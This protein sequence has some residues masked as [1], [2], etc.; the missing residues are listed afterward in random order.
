MSL[1]IE[2]EKICINQCI[3]NKKENIE[4]EGDVI[5]PDIKPDILKCINTCGTI[6]IYKKEV[7]DGKVRI[8]GTINVNIIY[9]TDTENATIRGITSTIDFSKTIEM[10]SAKQNMNIEC[11]TK[12]NGIECRI[13]NGRKVNLKAIVEVSIGLN[14][15]DEIEFIKSCDSID[16]IQ[17]LNQNLNI[18]TLVGMGNTNA[19]AKDTLLID[20]IDNL[21][22]IL[23]TNVD[24]I[25]IETKK[26]YNK[27]LIKADLYAKIMYLTDDGRINS[28]ESKIPIMGF[29]DMPDITED[30]ACETRY[31]LKNILVKPNNIEEHSIYVEAE[32][33]FNCLAFQNKEVKL[34][35]DS[36]SPCQNIKCD[37]KKINTIGKKQEIKDIC[38]VREKHVIPEIRN[39]KIYDVD[40]DCYIKKQ[41]V[42][43]NRITTE[44]EIVVNFIYSNSINNGIDVKRII[45]PFN[46]NTECE[47]LDSDAII[48]TNL[49]VANQDAIVMPDD[50]IELKIDLNIKHL[51]SENVTINVIKNISIEEDIEEEIYGITIYF[52]KPGDTLWNIAKKF[53][54]TTEAII[55]LNN[56]EDESRI[57]VGQ[58]IF[59]PKYVKDKA[60][61]S[62]ECKIKQMAGV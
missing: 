15:N 29:I 44:G 5:I 31:E 50:S 20:G 36:Y 32:V 37:Y 34:I 16:D 41:N 56:I 28:V 30:D 13:L 46:H 42:Y 61:I 54:S 51:V 33:E 43:N 12:L 26:S 35:E 45:V 52:V 49:E 58:Q 11:C 27:V 40:V 2:K 18:N 55:E 4:I 14:E 21:S 9:L 7:L 6:C 57:N 62:N 38:S 23:K 25:N 1:E 53:R 3:E 22:E 59:I 17:I 10:K 47:S 24:V 8:D 39:E 19:Q 60:N 48:D